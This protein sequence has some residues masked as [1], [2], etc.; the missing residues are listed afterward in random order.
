[1]STLHYH[2]DPKQLAARAEYA[3]SSAKAALDDAIDDEA[4]R[5]ELIDQRAHEI[6]LR[7]LALANA[8]DMIAGFHSAV[9]AN[10]QAIRTA[11]VTGDL[12]TLG[13]IADVLIRAYIKADSEV[14]SIEWLEKIE[15]EAG[16]FGEQS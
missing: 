1:M 5:D 2:I 8:D 6:E 16:L 9:D 14:E 12:M 3:T 13:R 15:R 10:A 4:E 7:R 11:F